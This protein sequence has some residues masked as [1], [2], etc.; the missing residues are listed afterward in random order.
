MATLNI[1]INLDNAAFE[2][3]SEVARIL[4]NLADRVEIQVYDGLGGQRV[5]HSLGKGVLLR[6]S[7]GNRVGSAQ[8]EED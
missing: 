3:S 5:V 1:E 6:D 7:N 2:D 8:V 4:R